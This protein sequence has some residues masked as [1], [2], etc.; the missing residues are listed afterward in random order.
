M[1]ERAC[2]NRE[3]GNLESIRELLDILEAAGVKDPDDLRARLATEIDGSVSNP[4]AIE[5]S[6]NDK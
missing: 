2:V 3:P 5:H 4:L 1:T 6:D